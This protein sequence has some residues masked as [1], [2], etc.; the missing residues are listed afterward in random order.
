MTLPADDAPL[1][2]ARRFIEAERL[3]LREVR[4]D[5]VNGRYYAWMN[6]PEVTRF[7]ESRFHPNSIESLRGYVTERLSDRTSVF[8]AIV[9]KDGDRHIGN[10]KIGPINW[11]HRHADIGLLI[12]EKDTWGKG[13]AT[14]A[15]QAVAAYGFGILNLHKLTAGCYDTNDGSARAFVKAGFAIEGRRTQHFYSDGRYVDMVLLG[16]VRDAAVSAR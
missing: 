8:L 11:I 3:Y 10:I 13:F 4:P 5:D 7:L 2:G 6:D 14:E 15:I 1:K 16:R 12:G 9:L